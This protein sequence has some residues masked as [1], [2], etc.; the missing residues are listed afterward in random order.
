MIPTKENRFMNKLLRVLAV[1]ALLPSLASAQP[2]INEILASAS[3]PDAD[4]ARDEAS[5]PARVLA[6]FDIG[7]GD[8]VADLLAGGGYYTRILVPLVGSTGLVY[9]GNN[10]FFRQFFGEAFDALLAEPGF[11]A[12][13]RADGPVDALPLPR[14]AS[15]D[16]VIM[17]QAYHDLV[18][19][20][21]DRGAM[22]RAVFA[23]LKPG[24]VYGI[25]DHAA[26][27]GSGVSTTES[28]H[29]IDKQFVI[30]EIEAAGFKLAAEA[31][32]LSNPNDDHSVGIFDPS[33]RGKTDRFVLRFEK[34]R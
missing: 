34:P 5:Q 29:R 22:N 7:Q 8:R 26:A 19:G 23:A 30:S 14:D 2:G 33:M 13:V 25:I 21:E 9:S 16:A 11:A 24:G 31:D 18:L 10:P 27:P 20:D 1:V 15:L 32:F 3:R 28:M 4:R 12:V 6:F 17:S